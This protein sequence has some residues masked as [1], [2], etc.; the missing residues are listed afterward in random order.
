[1]PG[2][3]N[4]GVLLQCMRPIL[5]S[6]TYVFVS[7]PS[8]KELP[9]VAVLATFREAAGLTLVVEQSI[10]DSHG[11]TYDYRAAWITLQVHSALEAVGLTAAV[12]SALAEAGISCN[13]WAAYYHDHIFVARHQ[14]EKAIAA[15]Q[16]LTTSIP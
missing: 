13:V 8:V 1:M 4:L 16:E 6:G 14:A 7:L 2:E 3:K 12:A 9:P 10:A 15:L 5:N 11:W